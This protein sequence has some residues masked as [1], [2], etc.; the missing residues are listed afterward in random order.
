[1]GSRDRRRGGHKALPYV[2]MPDHFHGLIRIPAREEE[3]GHKARPYGLGD[4]ICAFKSRV[5]VKYISGVKAGKWPRFPGKIWHRNYY[6]MIVWDA[7]AEE[8]ISRYIRMNPW[9]L[10]ME[11]SFDGNPFRCIGNPNLLNLAKVGILCSRRVPRG[12][13]LNPPECD[14]VFISGF[15]SPPEREILSVLLERRARV[16]C[17]PAWGID[18]MR[19]PK[20][21]LPA[22]EG[23]RMMVL[24][25]SAG[26]AGNLASAEERN[27]FVLKHAERMWMP[28]VSSG[29]MLERLLGSL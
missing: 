5:V 11:G 23:N 19:I 28:H 1:M 2:V 21:W 27:R 25:I 13:D 7:E 10:I 15:H 16:I 4:A 29:G 14:E 17:C 20:E 8:N 9:K 12:T 26:L 22:L 18:L 24:E 3:G 6:E